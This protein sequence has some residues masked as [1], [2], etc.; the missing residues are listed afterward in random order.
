MDLPY[1]DS[2]VYSSATDATLTQWHEIAA[3]TQHV[4]MSGSKQPLHY[5]ATAGHLTTNAPNGNPEASIFYVAYTVDEVD[6]ELRPLTFFFNGG[7]GTSTLWLHLGSW[8]PLRIL[9]GVPKTTVSSFPLVESEDTLL[10]DS[11][12]V[13]IDAPG[14]GYSQAIAP[15]TNK[16]FFNPDSDAAVFS[17]F[18]RRYLEINQR[19]QSPLYLYGES[20]GGFRSCIIAQLLETAGIHLTGI[21]M[22]SPALNF[23]EIPEDR[24]INILPT[25]A[26][27]STYFERSDKPASVNLQDYLKTVQAFTE[28]IYASAVMK[29]ADNSRDPISPQ[30]LTKLS[31]ITGLSTQ[32]V[33]PVFPYILGAFLDQLKPGYRLELTDGRIAVPANSQLAY[34]QAFRDTQKTYFTH[35]LKYISDS[36]YTIA[37]D[38]VWSFGEHRDAIPD[39]GTA[40]FQNSKLRILAISGYYDL[41]VPFMEVEKELGRLEPLDNVRVLQFEGGH[42]IYLTDSS[43]SQIRAELHKLYTVSPF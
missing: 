33:S 4:L 11:D 25:I 17:H 28:N 26:A 2:I 39:L 42:M 27:I 19:K 31:G 41:D 3:K 20:Y 13:F 12:L 10:F 6:N 35:I 32:I 9:T 14:T 5:T 43:R 21:V 38:P 30:A 40:L 23:R 22:N 34:R 37:R 24:L 7:P 16:T 8:G 18:I 36:P 1:N 29:Q 15:N